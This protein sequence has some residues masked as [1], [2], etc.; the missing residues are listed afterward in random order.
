MKQEK[1]NAYIK[2]ILINIIYV[3]IIK[4]IMSW[5]QKKKKLSTFCLFLFASGH[6]TMVIPFL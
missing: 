3:Y 2:N 6:G 4:S 1:E 5:D